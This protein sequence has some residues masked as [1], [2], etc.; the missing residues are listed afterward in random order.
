[1]LT[2]LSAK[3]QLQELTAGSVDVVSEEELLKKLSKSVST[4]KPLVIKAGFDPSRP[5]LHLGHAVLINKLRKFQDFGHQVI[6]LIG[7]FTAMIG[8]PTGKNVT[9]P[10]LTEEE[11]KIN[12]ITYARQVFKILDEKNT[13]VEYNSNWFSK[14]KASDF[15]KLASQYT[16]ARMLERDD[17][18]KRYQSRSPISLHELMY[19]LVQAYDSVAL[20]ADVELGGTDQ[21]FNL[22]VGREIQKSYGIEPQCVMTVPILEGLDGVQKM[23]KSL[24]NYIALED[25]PKEMFGKT[26]RLSDELM[27]RYYEL[28]SDLSV[29]DLAKLKSDVASGRRHPRDVKVSLAKFFVERF[30]GVEAAQAAE[31]EFNRIFKSGGLPDDIPEVVVPAGSVDLLNLMVTASLAESKGEA[32]RLVQQNAVEIA[33]EKISDPLIKIQLEKGAEKIIKAGKK[34]FAKLVVK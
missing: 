11:V 9:R 1:V 33:G 26:M 24:D 15:I 14:F 21:K 31:E 3:E 32:R 23:S 28:L 10:A 20:K 27:F 6:F 5:D 8:D 16:L 18:S 29:S 19:P 22:L 12:S 2:D 13:L 4:R 7:D 30:H 34:R 17:F 25:S